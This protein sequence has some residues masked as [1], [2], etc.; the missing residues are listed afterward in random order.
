MRPLTLPWPDKA[1][2][3]NARVHWSKRAEAAKSAR[4]A[5][6]LLAMA[7]RW[8][9]E[10]L[11]EGR[12]HLWITF[13]R[14]ARRKYDDDNLLARFKPMRDGLA[15]ALGIDDAR[16]VSHPFVSDEVRTGGE[17]VV[18]ITGGSDGQL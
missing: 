4:A 3:P 18:R 10:G 17:V 16:F 6:R 7:E 5:A 15:E 11:P 12:L 2:S 14:P 8:S 13:H 1:L 9:G